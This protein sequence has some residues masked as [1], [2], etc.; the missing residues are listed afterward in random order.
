MRNIDSLKNSA[1]FKE[2]YENGKSLANRLLAVYVLK[3]EGPF[4]LGISVSRKV[5]G[6]VIRHRVTRLI[7]ESY[8]SVKDSLPDDVWMVVIARPYCRGK[9]KDEIEAALRHMIKSHGLKKNG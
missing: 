8:I 7:R 3:K 2:V 1:E 6:S 5:G 9:S 4:R